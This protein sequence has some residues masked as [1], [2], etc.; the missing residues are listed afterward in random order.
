MISCDNYLLTKLS[1][2]QL[3][4]GIYLNY[5]HA[6]KQAACR[7]M[8]FRTAGCEDGCVYTHH[9]PS[10]IDERPTAA[11]RI[12]FKQRALQHLGSLTHQ[13]FDIDLIKRRKVTLHVHP[14]PYNYLL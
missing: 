13:R 11:A 7:N 9:L 4:V 5:K 2:A 6:G 1:T 8:D 3:F 14:P 12:G 10:G